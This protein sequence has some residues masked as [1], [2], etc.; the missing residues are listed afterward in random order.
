MQLLHNPQYAKH[1]YIVKPWVLLMY[2]VF[3][4]LFVQALKMIVSFALTDRVLCIASLQLLIFVT[5]CNSKDC[6][7][8]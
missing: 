1:I 2:L 6:Q 8:R 5:D 4:P 3:F 7:G